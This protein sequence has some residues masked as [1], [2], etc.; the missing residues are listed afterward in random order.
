MS[1]SAA[2]RINGQIGALERWGRTTAAQRQAA[3]R[4]ARK[5][6]WARFERLADP[7]GVMSA[8]DRI[9]AAERLQR[10]HMLRMAQAAA[11]SRASKAAQR[12]RKSA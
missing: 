6:M 3:T 5:G 1:D 11:K 4:A 12:S 9:E 8:A 7:D 2:H 10:A